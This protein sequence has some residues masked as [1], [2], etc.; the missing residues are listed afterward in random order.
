MDYSMRILYST[1]VPSRSEQRVYMEN[2]VFHDSL[3]R[4]DITRVTTQLL[5][6]QM[7]NGNR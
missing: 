1:R 3:K 6:I 5:T 2:R 7:N 4:E